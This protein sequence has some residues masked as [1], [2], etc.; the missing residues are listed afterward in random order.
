MIIRYD[1]KR[2]ECQ[3]FPRLR[4]HERS[5]RGGVSGGGGLISV[6]SWYIHARDISMDISI[7]IY[8]NHLNPW[9]YPT[10]ISFLGIS[11]ISISMDISDISGYI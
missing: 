6:T 10:Y 7:L 2:Q 5:L 4:R 11:R 9:I 3:F 8:P 1:M